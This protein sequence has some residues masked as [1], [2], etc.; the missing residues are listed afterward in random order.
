V[1]SA[2]HAALGAAAGALVAV[3]PD[4][5]LVLFGWRRRWLPPEHPLVRA[6]QLLHQPRYLLPVV[7]VVAWSSHVIA[8]QLTPHREGPP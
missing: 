6:H 4:A 7:A 8:D 1:S 3:A 5:V 2:R